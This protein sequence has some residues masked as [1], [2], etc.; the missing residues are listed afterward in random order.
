MLLLPDQ[1]DDEKNI[2][3]SS[4]PAK[5]KIGLV[6]LMIIGILLAAGMVT[7]VVAMLS[8]KKHMK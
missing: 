8:R 1:P 6:I 4:K 7:V 5:K 2:P 3:A